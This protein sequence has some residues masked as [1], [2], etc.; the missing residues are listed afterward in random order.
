[1]SIEITNPKSTKGIYTLHKV[2]IENSRSN[3]WEEAVNEWEIVGCD[4]DDNKSEICICGHEGL[5]YCFAIQNRF[6]HKQLYPIGS[7]CILQFGRDDLKETVSI[8]DQLFQIRT[9][10][11]KHE[12]IIIK[13]FSRKLLKFFLEEDVFKETRYNNFDP[14]NDYEFMLQMFN[15]RNEPSEKQ[16]SKINAIIMG[17]IIPYIRKMER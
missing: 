17:S 6:N 3:F 9:K 13:D 16:Q 8:Y 1:M 4:I 11:Y 14:E 15:R 12:K 2:V 10:Y 7:S 5:K